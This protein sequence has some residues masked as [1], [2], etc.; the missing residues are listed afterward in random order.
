MGP[1]ADNEVLPDRPNEFY[2]LGLL[3]PGDT[4]RDDEDFETPDSA[5]GLDGHSDGHGASGTGRV[6]TMRRKE[7]I[8]RI[9]FQALSGSAA[10]SLP[11]RARVT[12]E[13]RFATYEK[14]GSGGKETP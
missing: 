1:G 13:V 6:P 14:T 7:S 5:A 4:E 10:A 12:A 3:F 8:W 2:V 11:H 9:T